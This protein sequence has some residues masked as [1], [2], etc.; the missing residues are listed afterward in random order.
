MR[1]DV[2][3]HQEEYLYEQ[4]QRLAETDQQI[5]YM[6]RQ[7]SQLENELRDIRNEQLLLQKNSPSEEERKQAEEWPSIR[8]K[9]AEA[10]AYVQMSRSNQANGIP[11]LLWI[12]LI[13]AAAVSIVGLISD[14]WIV[15]GL[16]ACL[17]IIAAISAIGKRG[18]QP[19]QKDVEMERFVKTYIGQEAMIEALFEEVRGYDQKQSR[20][21]EAA[22]TIERKMGVLEEEYGAIVQEKE[23]HEKSLSGFFLAYGLRKIPNSGILHEF[24]GTVRSLQEIE[25]ELEDIDRQSEAVLQDI[26]SRQAE[27]EQLI[28]IERSGII[29]LR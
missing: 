27:V 1:A 9:L 7:L 8:S 29:D 22:R 10:K 28:S 12:L 6:D 17:A 2:S 3:I 5:G 18:G 4:L 19:P 13:L 15:V 24:F 16:G 21:A 14:Q 25:R 11:Q 26:R 23:Q 20:L